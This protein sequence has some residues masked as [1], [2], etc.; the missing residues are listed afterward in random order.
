MFTA[1][2]LLELSYT[3]R[4]RK[5]ALILQKE[6]LELANEMPLDIGYLLGLLQTIEEH[7]TPDILAAVKAFA[8]THGLRE[9]NSIRHLLLKVLGQ[10][11]SEWDFTVSGSST[12]DTVRRQ[13]QPIC[14]YLEDIRSPFNVGSLFRTAECFGV[15][16]LYLSPATP[17]PSHKKADRTARGAAQILAWS[18]CNL[19]QLP[20][21]NVIFALETGG[22]PVAEYQFPA[23]GL[24]LIG[25]EELGLSPAALRLADNSAGRVGI[26]LYGAKRSLNVSVAFG[27]LMEHWSRYL[28]A[29]PQN[30]HQTTE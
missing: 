15:Q 4:L 3:T 28:L 8:A 22:I 25:S 13:V 19:E 21:Q 9:L 20:A 30:A 2:K 10:E 18:V 11:P 27:I 24:V 6:E 16:A 1:K 26:P 12:L 29:H 17:L 5:L 23:K 14:A 7:A